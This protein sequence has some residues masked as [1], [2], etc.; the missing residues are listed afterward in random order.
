MED[1]HY[2]VM[3]P[4]EDEVRPPPFSSPDVDSGNEDGNNEWPCSRPILHTKEVAGVPTTKFVSKP[5]KVAVSNLPSQ[6]P[7]IL[8]DFTAIP[9]GSKV[10]I[11]APMVCCGMRVCALVDSGC[12]H[13]LMSPILAHAL[14][15]PV[16]P[17]TGRIALGAQGVFQHHIWAMWFVQLSN[18][19]AI[20]EDVAVELLD[21][22]PGYHL[23]LGMDILSH[24]GISV[25]GVS[26]H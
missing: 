1:S 14:K 23:I 21:L 6:A 8:P 17:A 4:M 22:P 5:P 2:R 18:M 12:T 13:T 26:P 3:A 25:T 10:E 20:C 24:L 16:E 15:L 19:V 9:S 11:I 7:L